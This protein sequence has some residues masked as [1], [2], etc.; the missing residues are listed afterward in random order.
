M[1]AIV[2]GYELTAV[3]SEMSNIDIF[4]FKGDHLLID[5][6]ETYLPTITDSLSLL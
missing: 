5:S 3:S 6:D 4:I 2:K 1:R